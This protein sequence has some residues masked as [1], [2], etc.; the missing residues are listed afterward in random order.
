[1]CLGNLTDV[2]ASTVNEKVTDAAHVAVIEHRCPEF[3][4]QDEVGAV[5]GKPTQVHESLQIQNLT[6]TTGCE[7]SSPAVDRDGACACR[8]ETVSVT[9]VTEQHTQ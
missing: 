1:M 9:T 3:G 8:T 2:F 4:G 7:R 6:F 5:G